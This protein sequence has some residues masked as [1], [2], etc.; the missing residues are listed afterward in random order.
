MSNLVNRMRCHFLHGHIAQYFL[1]LITNTNSHGSVGQRY[2]TEPNGCHVLFSHLN[3]FSRR[4]SFWPRVLSASFGILF[5]TC[6][7]L[8]CVSARLLRMNI[9][10]FRFVCLRAWLLRHHFNILNAFCGPNPYTKPELSMH[11]RLS[12]DLSCQNLPGF[13]ESPTDGLSTLTIKYM[14]K[15][16]HSRI[17]PDSL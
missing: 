13:C 5:V 10:S 12:P 8:L 7:V 1:A 17:D 4:Q 16:S 3:R 9:N 14:V 6:V 11:I 2:K 15:C